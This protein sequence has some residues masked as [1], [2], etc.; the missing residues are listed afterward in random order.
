MC[1]SVPKNPKSLNDES[2]QAYKTVREKGLGIDTLPK[3]TDPSYKNEVNRR[4]LSIRAVRSS[5]RI[6]TGNLQSGSGL[7]L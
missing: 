2:V 1:N 3:T 5:L 6:P 7:Q 4:R